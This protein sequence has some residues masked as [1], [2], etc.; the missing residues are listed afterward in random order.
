MSR[1][2]YTDLLQKSDKEL[3]AMLD[4]NRK[5]LSETLVDMRTKQVANVKQVGAIKRQI[6][7][8]L[9]AQRQRAH[10]AKEENHG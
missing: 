10:A 9:T 7:Q 1:M 6:A 2:K 8:L 3:A 5:K 4:D